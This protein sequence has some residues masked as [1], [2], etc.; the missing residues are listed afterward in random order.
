VKETTNAEAPPKEKRDSAGLVKFKTITRETKAQKLERLKLIEET[1]VD[2]V[3]AEHGNSCAYGE[4]KQGDLL[5][6]TNQN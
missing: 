4:R 1:A 3:M 2:A 6:M 5:V